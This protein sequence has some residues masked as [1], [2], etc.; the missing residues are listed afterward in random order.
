M[1]QPI[2]LAVAA[3]IVLAASSN[4]VSNAQSRPNAARV[5]SYLA[6][7]LIYRTGWSIPGKW[8][9]RSWVDRPDVLING[10][11]NTALS[12]L[13]GEGTM[14]LSIP[15]AGKVAGTFDMGGGYVLD[16][17]GTIT[18]AGTGQ[19]AIHMAGL[20]R[21][22][23]PTA[24]WEYDYDGIT[25]ERW[26]KGVAQVPAFTGSVFRAKP[27]DGNPAGFVASFIAVKKP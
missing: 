14:T 18:A 13:F 12:L 4:S 2:L 5:P 19:T 20:G 3:S 27:H 25:T 10:D 21:A 11:A 9:Y 23:T 24:G 1:K 16:L 26:P 7:K 17:I 8:V 22:G 6:T 15:S